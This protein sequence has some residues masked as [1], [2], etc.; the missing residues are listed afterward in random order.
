MHKYLTP[1]WALLALIPAAATALVVALLP[2][3]HHRARAQAPGI[4]PAVPAAAT[5]TTPA[6]AAKHVELTLVTGNRVELSDRGGRAVVTPEPTRD[7]RA[8]FAYT[9]QVGGDVYSIPGAALPY[10][11]S[12][13]D[14]RFFDISYLHRAGYADQKAL[15]VSISWR[16]GKHETIPGVT[17]PAQGKTTTGRIELAGAS[18]F[19]QALADGTAL[20]QVNKITLGALPAASG[21]QPVAPAVPMSVA[22]PT[23]KL[24]SL[25]VHTVDVHGA[26]GYAI[27]AIQNLKSLTSYYSLA[28]VGPGDDVRV[29]VPAGPYGIEAVIYDSEVGGFPQDI[30]FVA[31]PEVDVAHDT[32]VTLNARS[33]KP[34]QVS[35]PKPAEPE[36]AALTFGR[37]SAD[38]FGLSAGL[39]TLGPGV[40]SAI[41]PPVHMYAAP[42]AKPRLGTLGFA[43]SWELVPA[44][45]G[46]GGVAAPYAYNLDFASD[47]GVPADLSHTLTARDLATVHDRYAASVPGAS[48][49]SVA[50][51]FHD[52][53]TLAIALFPVVFDYP[54]PAQRDDYFGGSTSTVWSQAYQ[55]TTNSQFT[56]PGIFGPYRTFGPGTESSET[57]GAS[58]SVPAPEWQNMAPRPGSAPQNGVG[59]IT[60]AY[61]CP[62]CRQGDVLAFNV[63]VSGDNDPAHS[64]DWFGLGSGTVASAAGH[65]SDAVRFYRNG[66]LTQLGG[67]SGQMFPML[68]GKASYT[69]DWASTIPTAWTQLATSVH[70]VWTFTSSR[71]ARADRLP[72]YE[73]CAPDVNQACS[74]VPLVFAGYDFGADL[75][76]QV[77]GGTTGTFTLT[78]YHEA[79]ASAPPVNHA[80]VQVSLDDGATWAPAARVTA[81]G[82]GRFRV[83]VDQPATT[84]YVSIKVALSDGAGNS[85]QQTIIRA[86]ALH[87]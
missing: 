62:V 31:R 71:P 42:A 84:G 77:L 41:L 36:I 52:W 81:L 8:S 79:G 47:D 87:G 66:V 29:S 13:L 1:R 12:R 43:H 44:D 85:L 21:S 11:G 4:R 20:A 82:G 70:S 61:V 6:A 72:S 9:F 26:S 78:G 10:V 45:S 38:G 55:P 53:S 18:T 50:V 27:V 24:Y 39:Y 35:V 25:A 16:Q 69:I 57:W 75:S 3:S 7:V 86:Y 5:A 59:R 68:P 15:P 30:A 48:G 14:P 34:I 73:L 76:G 74:F 54:V 65:P 83:S 80:F 40:S 64:E 51:P 32:A 46:L 37:G 33:A 2:G 49:S 60:W 56:S 67:V 58:P 22:K 17:T 28:A 19:G 23:G 63:P